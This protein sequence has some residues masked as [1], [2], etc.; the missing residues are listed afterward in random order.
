MMRWRIV[1]MTTR[2]LRWSA[3]LGPAVISVCPEAGLAARTAPAHA[4]MDMILMGLG[5]VRFDQTALA[6]ALLAHSVSAPSAS[7]GQP[8]TAVEDDLLQ[9]HPPRERIGAPQRVLRR[10][11]RDQSLRRL[12]L[13]ANPCV[14]APVERT[15]LGVQ[16]EIALPAD[17]AA[18][19][20]TPR[21]A[22]VVARDPALE[23]A[24]AGLGAARAALGDVVVVGVERQRVD[25]RAGLRRCRPCRGA[26]Q[27]AARD[28]ERAHGPDLRAARFGGGGPGP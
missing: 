8:D 4:D 24:G 21:L 12:A 17:A 11:A 5:T 15:A 22:D 16:A 19:V 28:D 26:H 14:Q 25:R 1:S 9:A 20:D 18:R 10:Q 6:V 13:G 7:V 2:S 23:R 27:Q 3:R